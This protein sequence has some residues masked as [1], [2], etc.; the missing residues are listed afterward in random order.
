MLVLRNPDTCLSRVGRIQKNPYYWTPKRTI[1][2][3]V[4][5]PGKRPPVI[6]MK[7]MSKFSLVVHIIHGKCVVLQTN[8]SA[9]QF[10]C[11]P[12]LWIS[13]QFVCKPQNGINSKNQNN[14]TYPANGFLVYMNGILIPATG[15]ASPRALLPC[16]IGNGKKG[17]NL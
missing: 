11:K 6:N 8:T 7:S 1:P 4:E 5:V 17:S 12:M 10:F 16:F 15:W 9:N 2:R 3:K 14:K 13:M